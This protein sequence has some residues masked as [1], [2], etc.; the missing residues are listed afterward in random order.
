[1][2]HRLGGGD[3][4]D[5]SHNDDPGHFSVEHRVR[6]LGIH[7]APETP[8]PPRRLIARDLVL[9]GGVVV[10]AL[11]LVPFGDVP[12]PDY[13]EARAQADGLDAAYR[14]VW[15]S[16]TSVADAADDEGLLVFEFP[17]GDQTITVL[18]HAQPTA[19]G[20]CYGLRLGGGF[21]T[22]AV[23]FLPSDGCVPQGRWAFDET[24]G[25]DDVLGTER[26]TSVWFVPALIV[27]VGI[28]VALTTN[29]ILK[30]LPR[31]VR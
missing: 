7:K 20:M 8:S 30:L 3:M 23:R 11:L 16:E 5:S 15:S 26:V 10:A 1:M 14:S 22:D 29:I 28:G 2:Q 12:N 21:G 25:W 31:H 18:T 19:A 17:A 6:R 24:G 4:S 13:P 9:L 27:L